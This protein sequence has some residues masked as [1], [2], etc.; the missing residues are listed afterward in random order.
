MND[1]PSLKS[2]QLP[3]SA[4]KTK[5]T[6]QQSLGDIQ[7]QGDD[8]IFNVV[9]ADI[10]TLTQNKIIQISVD[11]IKTREFITT[12]PYK[13]LRSF[14][15]KDKDEFFGRDQ[16]I[17]G[18]A[19]ELEHTN[20]VLLLGASG[21]GKSS[22][23]RAGLIPWLSQKWGTQWVNL[24]L[25]PD[26]DPFESLHGSLLSHFR[27]SEAQLVRKGEESTLSQL[28]KTLKVPEA[29]WFIFIDQ[30][31]ELFT[32]SD[33]EKRDRFIS[34]LAQ[35]CQEHADTRTL[36]IVATMRSDFLDRFDTHPANLL[37]K[38][39]EGHRPLITQLHPD[40]LRLAIEQPAA[41]HGV[42]FETGLVEE[43]IKDVQ[44]QAGY[45]PLL[46]YTLNMLWETEVSDG[47]IHDRTLNIQSYRN[48][49]GV[50]GAL[51]QRV[52]EIYQGLSPSGQLA[53]QRIFLKLV[54]I[55]G[56]TASETDW[57][58][59]RKR[60]LRSRFSDPL[61]QTVLTELIDANLL[62]S[63]GAVAD[64]STG[65]TVEIA[66]EVLLTSW[67]QLQEWI[68]E[69]REAIALRNRLHDDVTQWR[70]EKP[71]DE[72]WS[73]VKLAKAVALQNED[74]FNQ[75][76][77]GFDPEVMAFIEASVERR[78]RL[79]KEKED[80]RQR[81]LEQEKKAR[82][83]AQR[84]T[85]G[86]SIGIV[87]MTGLAAF[88]GW[89]MR[90]AEI[91]QIRTSV[92]LSKTALAS[93]HTLDADVAGIRAARILKKSFWQ[94]VMPDN[95]LRASV[96]A[97]L[98][99]TT[100]TGREQ[101]RLEHQDGSIYSFA[102]NPDGTQMAT[103]GVDGTIRLWD[104]EGKQLTVLEKAHEGLIYN[105]AYSPD[106][107]QIATNG[108]D[109][110]VGLWDT[111]G[112][113]LAVLEDPEGY[114]S[115]VAFSPDGTQ[116]VT[117]GLSED[118]TARLWDAKGKQ[119]AVLESHEGYISSVA[120]SPDSTQLVTGGSDGTAH[121]WDT[122]GKQLAVLDGHEGYISSVAFS[123]DGTQLAT[124]AIDGTTRLWDTTGKQLAV[125]EHPTGG[126][127]SVAYSPDG[128]QL[129]TGGTNGTAR[130]WNT[131]GN[132]LAVFEGHE[133]GITD[134]AYSPDGTQLATGGT[135]GTARLW[136]TTGKQ[137]AVLNGH[138]GRIDSVTFSPNGT[139]M[140]TGGADEDGTVRL[141]D[142]KGN[143]LAA[144]ERDEGWISVAHSP[145][146]NQ[147]AT[148]G[149]DGIARL[150]NIKGKQL[151]VLEGS[152]KGKGSE[153]G[154]IDS[155]AYSPDG[156]Q[157][158][159]IDEDGI[160]RL[161][162]TQGKQLVVLKSHEGGIANVAFSPD[163]TQLI[164]R[165]LYEDGT[166]RL[167][168]TQGKQLAVLKSHEGEI[169]SVAYSP[170]ST[171]LAIGGADGTVRLWDTQGKQRAVLKGHE[172]WIASVAFSPDG[173][174]LITR[175]AEDGTAR[176]W[177]TQKGKQLT[178]LKGHKGGISRI[179]FSPDGTQLA[180]SGAD[181]TARL[182]NTQGKQLAVLKGHE[183][184]I[185]NVAFSPDGNQ[186]ATGGTDGTARLW[187]TKG[188]QLA[189]LD[190]HKGWITNV[191]FSPDG[192]RLATSEAY[193]SVRLWDTSGKLLA[194]L[195]AHKGEIASITFSPDGTQLLANGV[196]RSARLWSIHGIDEL[197]SKQC[198]WVNN[199]LTHNVNVDESD[200]KLCD[201]IG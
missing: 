112:K 196:Y 133:G 63:D 8:N 15:P 144:L 132:P 200:R 105:V 65:A 14:E 47:G 115:S 51:Q 68:R 189:V 161:W 28:V 176:L 41:H 36:K 82:K 31:E 69:N 20:F 32:T 66:H 43:I 40:E 91:Q 10:V 185:T 188:K 13:G 9:Q 111:Q 1:E 97:Q 61:E 154:G 143:P 85:L 191:T 134:I 78:D 38:A 55:G 30:F 94:T 116:L 129:A 58:P 121:L 50:R 33:V 34:S 37:V 12:S 76:L 99:K 151:A 146:G 175:G 155:I 118:E 89:Q 101:N 177:D 5:P 117:H 72:L 159:A 22:V 4:E 167:W 19:N 29:Y 93:N 100:I 153:G 150:W 84:I 54:G 102:Y 137:L 106:G 126:I 17:A 183:G 21:S 194:V 138:E 27:Q 26:Q 56:N 168:N 67:H 71:D 45:L 74:T 81:E 128:T 83:T 179:V 86:A 52:D 6:Q 80:Q 103:G 163:G 131:K 2:A 198:D 39:T 197:L 122:R 120:F 130:L 11:E 139:Q 195:D 119:L 193:Q 180:T 142:T 199:Y 136:D 104:T 158:V 169:A 147:L 88:S 23:V 190:S 53:T 149:A 57:K 75:V 141:W 171:Q 123:P 109:G 90:Q 87:L 174:Q 49:G 79:E 124:R 77:G 114:I 156:N 113:Q 98:Q 46:Q 157:L 25:T 140:A 108:F 201:G 152:E 73:G 135:N 184:G 48:I 127:I 182:W 3:G 42:V 110:T 166:A 35:L 164:T 24:T 165:G 181:G 92:A 60:E 70:P 18:L 62:V 145:D 187:N 172:G 173:T 192:T 95:K 186:L 178:I 125:L 162:N 16:F 148:S 7:L 64:E 59:V 107:T 44:G 96:L 160:V 170:D